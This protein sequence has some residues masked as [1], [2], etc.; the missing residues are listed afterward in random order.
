MKDAVHNPVSPPE[1]QANGTFRYVGKDSI[2]VL[3]PEGKVV[4]A[5]ARNS[6]GWRNP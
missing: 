1:A 2:V 3:N 4:T 6:G 5:W